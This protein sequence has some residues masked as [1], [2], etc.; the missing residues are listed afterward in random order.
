MKFDAIIA[1]AVLSLSAGVTAQA[2]GWQAPA[3][4]NYAAEIQQEQAQ[5]EAQQRQQQAQQ[6]LQQRQMDQQRQLQNRPMC[7]TYHR[8]PFTGQ[9]TTVT[10][11]CNAF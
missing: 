1:I 9:T 4:R 7:T 5:R 10:Q 11:P 8:D 2:Q 3:P 6:E